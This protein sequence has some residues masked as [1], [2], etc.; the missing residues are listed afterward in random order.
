LREPFFSKQ[1]GKTSHRAETKRQEGQGPVLAGCAGRKNHISRRARGVRGERPKT[2]TFASRGDAKAQRKS[3]SG[4][5]RTIVRKTVSGQLRQGSFGF[6]RRSRKDMWFS[7][8]L[9]VS[10]CLAALPAYLILNG[11]S[12]ENIAFMAQ[13]NIF[14]KG[15]L[16]TL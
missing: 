12:R 9:C 10:G 14:E 16:G 5:W 11:G 7:L 3:R 15:E 2:K 8:R 13:P 4:F 6:I 1:E